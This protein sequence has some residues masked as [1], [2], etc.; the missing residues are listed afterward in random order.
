MLPPHLGH[1]GTA[2]G[3][4]QQRRKRKPRSAAYRMLPFE[5][6]DVIL[7]PRIKAARPV[8]RTAHADCRVLAAQSDGERVSHE[9]PQRDQE[10][11]GGAG[12][13]S[14]GIYHPL[15]MGAAQPGHPPA[16]VLGPA[17]ST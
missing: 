3:G 13:P 12:G 17:P 4:V 8:L 2:L 14:L 9:S 1:V 5:C 7:G 11:H 16:A 15:D 6:R 10:I